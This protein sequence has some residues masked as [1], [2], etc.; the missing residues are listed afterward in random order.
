MVPDTEFS[1]R[2]LLVSL[3]PV[4]VEVVDEVGPPVQG[5]SLV[6][7]LNDLRLSAQ[8]REIYVAT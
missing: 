3:D 1:L 7:I 4:A 8:F 6:R 5:E 2:K